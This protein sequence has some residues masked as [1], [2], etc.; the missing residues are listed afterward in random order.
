MCQFPPFIATPNDGGFAATNSGV[1]GISRSANWFGV[2]ELE[3][4]RNTNDNI[5]GNLKAS[6]EILDG[7][8]Y[9]LN[10]SLNYRN[11]R[12]FVFTPTYFMSNTDVGS[13]ELAD[14]FD[15]RT[16]FVSTIV[17]NLLSYKKEFND[18]NISAL[19][20]YSEQR[21]KTETLLTQGEDFFSNDTRTI[22]A[23]NSIVLNRGDLLPRN[24]RSVFGQINY[25]FKQKYL[26]SGSLRRDG[27]SNFGSGNR[28]GVFPSFSAGW[29]ISEESFF[30]VSFVDFLKVRG[31]WGQLGSDNLIPFQFITSLNT[32]SQYTL[33]ASQERINGVAQTVFSN[34]N[35]KW[36]ETTTTDIGIDI[37]L[38]DRSLELQVDYFVKDSEDILAS[39]PVN[40]TSG[41]SDPVPVNAASIRNQG[42]EF[43][44]TYSK[45][46]GPFKY[47][48]SANLATLDNE[49]L[50]L[51]EGI[52]PIAGALTISRT[53]AG[54]PV[55][56]FYGFKTDGIYQSQSEIDEDNIQ[57]RTIVPGDL[58]FVDLNNDN[59]ID[60][61]DRTFIGN[62]TPDI[63]YG[64]N[65]TGSYK[66]LDFGIFF[67]GVSGNEIANERINDGVFRINNN[68]LGIVRD[69]WT[70]ENP[71]NTVPR[72]TIADAGNNRDISDF[73]IENGA[74]FRLRNLSV[75]YKIPLNDQS[76]LTNLRLYLN[77]ENLFIIDDYSG[78]YPITGRVDTIENPNQGLVGRPDNLFSRGIDRNVYPTARTFTF[79][80]QAS[81]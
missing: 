58:R 37:G 62:P 72:A 65:F 46:D 7:L 77:A 67:Q 19:V 5:L 51:G 66:N 16:T 41:T 71:S 80:I 44:T 36:E 38:F 69:A 56:Y 55:G 40:P 43:V 50:S 42:L 1:A 4:R 32:T 14:I 73:W 61:E 45:R 68:K 49:V 74:Y 60:D 63:T 75:G 78:Y 9:T 39:L 18:H 31:S 30:T 24:I 13:N 22:S 33:G 57:N 76:L 70:P 53:E 20:G 27:S 17:E 47:S 10:L 25:N 11:T 6:Y 21:D 34:P 81:F 29:N 52:N 15:G 3:E 48:I 26:L 64:I 35:L 59:V 8:E 79:G 28:F 23:A 2:S 12:N 54:F